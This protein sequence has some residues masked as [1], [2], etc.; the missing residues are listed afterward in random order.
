[1]KRLL[2]FITGPL[3]VL[4]IAFAIAN[5]RPVTLSFDPFSQVAPALGVEMPLWAV[6]FIPLLIGVVLG[7][8]A[9]WTATAERRIRRAAQQREASKARDIPDPLAGV[10]AIAQVKA[11]PSPRGWRRVLAWLG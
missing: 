10:P 8:I 9:S 2:W 4:L 1:M 3:A 5:R 6:A 11:P 7:G